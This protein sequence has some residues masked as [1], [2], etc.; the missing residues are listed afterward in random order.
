MKKVNKILAIIPFTSVAISILYLLLVYFKC[1]GFEYF[2]S[3]KSYHKDII[4]IPQSIVFLSLIV[5][6]YSSIG[7]V[8]LNIIALYIILYLLVV[9]Y[10]FLHSFIL[11]TN[12]IYLIPIA[13][14]NKKIC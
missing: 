12:S 4:Q 2:K 8:L 13:I 9:G 6:F 10:S 7:F 3:D 1:D 14:F 11:E 5:T